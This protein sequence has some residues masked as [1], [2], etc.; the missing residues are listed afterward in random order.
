MSRFKLVDNSGFPVTDKTYKS[1]SHARIAKS[2]LRG[3]DNK[4]QPII[5]PVNV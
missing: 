5:V 2:L 4:Y 3:T 1:K